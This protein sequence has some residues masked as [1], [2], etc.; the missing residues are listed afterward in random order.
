MKRT[1]LVRKTPLAAKSPLTRTRFM[2][3]RR[4]RVRTTAERLAQQAWKDAVGACM[5]C[6]A[7]G[8]SCVGPVQGHHAVSKQA[9]KKRGLFAYLWDLRNKVDVCEHRHEQHTSGFK[10]IP[11]DLLPPAVFEF[12]GD[13][14][15]RWWLDRFYPATE[16]AAA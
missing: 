14:G 15:L 8:G 5:V 16:A 11:R 7:E 12:A 6:P 2:S 3:S 9:L 4:K 1:A 13:V 10:P